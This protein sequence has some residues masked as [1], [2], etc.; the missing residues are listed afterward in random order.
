MKENDVIAENMAPYPIYTAMLCI[1]W[2]G[3]SANKRKIIRRLQTFSQLFQEI[4]S[5]L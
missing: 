5:F 1:L 4:V 3:S 2:R